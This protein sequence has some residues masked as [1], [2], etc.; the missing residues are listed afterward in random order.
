MTTYS[1]QIDVPHSVYGLCDYFLPKKIEDWLTKHGLNY[2]HSGVSSW[3]DGYTNGISNNE[4]HY[5][6][7]Y[8]EKE[9]GSAF[10]IMFPDCKVHIFEYYE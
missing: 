6:I 1:M 2:S 3:G 5:V 10:Q 8:M 4:S 9:D 7:R